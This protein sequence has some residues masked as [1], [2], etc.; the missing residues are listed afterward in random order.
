MNDAATSPETAIK[1]YVFDA[2]GTLFDVHS[3]AG[4][5]Q[6][7]I[8]PCADQLSNIWRTKQLLYTWIR[9]MIGRH[10]PFHEITAEALDFA[11]ESVGGVPE[12]TRNG[13]LNAY[14]TLDAYPEVRDVL[15]SLKRSGARLAVLSNGSPMML[16]AAVRSAGIA[17]VLDDVFSIEQVGIYKPDPRVYAL[18]TD[19]YGCLP[20]EVSFQSSN[21]WDIAGAKAFGFHTLW[22]NR[23]DQPDELKDMAPDRVVASL[24]PLLERVT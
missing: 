3:A 9:S 4:R 22:I 20:A 16:E 11:I 24:D 1:A 8:G 14:M 17:D 15:G 21:R 18:V 7:E 2:Y 23:F 13:L 6:H 10:K 12:G 5:L 19:A